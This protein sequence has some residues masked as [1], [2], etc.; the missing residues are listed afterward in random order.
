MLAAAPAAW[1]ADGSIDALNPT[2]GRLGIVFSALG[3]PA[4][5]SIDL[6]SVQVRLDGQQVPA[7]AKPIADTAAASQRSTMLVLDASNSMND[8]TTDGQQRLAAA[9][10]AADAY[11][12]QVPKDVR[13]GLLTFADTTDLRVK[14]TLDRTA[15]RVALNSITLRPGTSLFDGVVAAT[16]AL[17][18]TGVRNMLL[19]ADGAD[20]GS[21]ATLKS[22]TDAILKAKVGVDAVALGTADAQLLPLAAAGGGVVVPASQASQ[23]DAAFEAAAAAQASQ[24]VID[25][26]V[27]AEF[28]GKSPTVIVQASAGGQTIGDER[29]VILSAATADPVDITEA[30]GPVAVAPTEPG[31]SSQSWFLPAAIA[32]VAIGLFGMLAVAFV[33][34]RPREPAVGP[35][36][37]PA[38]PL[39]PHL[40]AG[41]D[42]AGRHP[43][44]LGQSQVARSAVELAGRVTQSRDLDTGLGGPA[45][46]RRG[47]PP[48]RRVAADPPRHRHRRR[49]RAH[50]AVGLQRARDDPGSRLSAW[51]CPMR[52]SRSRRAGARRRSP[53]RCPT[54][55]S[56]WRGRWRRATPSRRRST[57]WRASPAGRWGSSST[58]RWSK[59]A[60]ACPSRT[61]WRRSPAG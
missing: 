46:G 54:P 43:G 29:V 2:A 24:V 23:L 20:G 1:A 47:S 61:P 44:A 19:L 28:A 8:T 37:P 48:S 34:D 45:R 35:G 41:A 22:A 60:S 55:C 25:A 27:P 39:L 51:V 4:G 3:L 13:V 31:L 5:Q 6:T 26:V 14:P 17:G 57:R 56:C 42:D 50:A 16:A 30:Y 52:T 15:V 11:L 40:P 9:V 58:G 12:T 21:T 32:A 7:T 18:T 53:Q 59:P 10:A 49:P 33:L 38:E 36:S